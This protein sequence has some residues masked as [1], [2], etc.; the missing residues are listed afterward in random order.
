MAED[1]GEQ[2]LTE[3]VQDSISPEGSGGV[4]AEKDWNQ[5]GLGDSSTPEDKPQIDPEGPNEINTVDDVAEKAASETEDPEKPDEKEDPDKKLE[6]E[7]DRF[8]KHPRFQELNTK[9]GDLASENQRLQGMVDALTKAIPKQEASEKEEAPTFT[10]VTGK[11]DE[12]LQEWFDDSPKEF[13]ANFAEQVRY[14]VTKAVNAENAQAKTKSDAQGEIGKFSEKHPDFLTKW[15]SG[16][17]QAVM[18]KYPQGFHNAISAYH[19]LTE[20]I[21]QATMEATVQ[22]QIDKAV[23]EAEK[24]VT[25]NFKAKRRIAPIDSSGAPKNSAPDQDLKDTKK[26]GGLVSAIA[27]RI[28]RSRQTA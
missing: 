24:R 18:N 20:P 3:L 12:E 16:E 17:I 22:E 26:S 6:G 14:E 15:E 11:T 19:E 13:M 21:K 7:D 1:K 8:D 5:G 10:D 9:V 27:D 23:K 4:D 28:N 25:A 2:T